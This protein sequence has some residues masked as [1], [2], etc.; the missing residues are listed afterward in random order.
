ME[1]GI[2][3]VQRSYKI[4][5]FVVSLHYLMKR[6]AVYA[7]SDVLHLKKADIV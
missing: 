4:N 3:T 7:F 2:D 1:T 5:N 6:R